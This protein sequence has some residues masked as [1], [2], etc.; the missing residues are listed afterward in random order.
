MCF[1]SLGSAIDGYL[2][3]QPHGDKIQ[4]ADTACL[5]ISGSHY[6]L[7]KLNRRGMLHKESFLQGSVHAHQISYTLHIMNDWRCWFMKFPWPLNLPIRL[8]LFKLLIHIKG[9][10]LIFLIIVR[11]CPSLWPITHI[12]TDTSA[13]VW[14]TSKAFVW[15]RELVFHHRC[16]QWPYQSCFK[17]I[18]WMS[19][20]Y[21]LTHLSICHPW[22]KVIDQHHN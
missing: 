4:V 10:W 3:Q 12:P 11:F 17:V 20:D 18:L 21:L 19:S 1:G 7:G 13:E 8:W 22:P 6:H 5:C 9:I 16:R 15:L 14:H 2:W